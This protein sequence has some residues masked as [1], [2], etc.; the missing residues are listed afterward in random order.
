MGTVSWRSQSQSFINSR[1]VLYAQLAI[2]YC[3]TLKSFKE[4]TSLT[5]LY[6][7]IYVTDHSYTYK[8]TQE[9]HLLLTLKYKYETLVN[10]RKTKLFQHLNFE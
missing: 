8:Q 7:E 10:Y 3:L 4:H 9:H 6:L 5:F 2:K 1:A